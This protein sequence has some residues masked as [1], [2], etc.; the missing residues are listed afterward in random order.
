MIQAKPIRLHSRTLA[1]INEK[2]TPSFCWRSLA[3]GVL[4]WNRMVAFLPLYGEILS[5]NKARQ[6]GAK[7]RKKWRDWEEKARER[8]QERERM[9]AS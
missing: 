9:N 7:P 5:E 4:A 1:G 2:P 6:R 8:E 3:H